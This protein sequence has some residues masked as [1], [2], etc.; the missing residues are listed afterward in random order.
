MI[1]KEKMG[2]TEF[3]DSEDIEKLMQV[4]KQV[5][6]HDIDQVWMMASIQAI[7]QNSE[8][9]NERQKAIMNKVFDERFENEKFKWSQDSKM[10]DWGHYINFPSWIHIKP[11]PFP[12]ALW[13]L[14]VSISLIAILYMTV[15][16][17]IS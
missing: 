10:M 8:K 3:F 16:N 5:I 12:L 14:S 17:Y 2:P 15:L 7:M 1:E 6:G 11:R 13:H 9:N 4:S